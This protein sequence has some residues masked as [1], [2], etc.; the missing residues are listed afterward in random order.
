MSLFAGQHTADQ[1]WRVEGRT[2]VL[3]DGSLWI[4]TQCIDHQWRDA[5]IPAGHVP[6][7]AALANPTGS[8]RGD[9]CGIPSL[10]T[11]LAPLVLGL[12]GPGTPS[13][14]PKS[15]VCVVEVATKGGLTE[16]RRA[17]LIRLS[18]SRPSFLC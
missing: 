9:R 7:L 14:T 11:L 5:H 2:G 18:T 16:L 8:L 13:P 15:S 17:V 10:V 1:N 3:Q 4:N 12:I 6:I